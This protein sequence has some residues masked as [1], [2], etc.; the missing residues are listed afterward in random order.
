MRGASLIDER[1]DAFQSLTLGP[2]RLAHSGDVKIYENLNVLPR[3]FIASDVMLSADGA[4]HLK[5]ETL[6][7]SGAQ[8][9]SISVI[10][11]EAER[12][13]IQTTT[14]TPGYLILTDEYYPGWL[15]TVD[16]QPAAITRAYGLFRAVALQ[17]GAHTVEFRFDPP[18]LKLG[19][20][21]SALTLIALIVLFIIHHSTFNIRHS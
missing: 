18:A 19:V 17:P 4:K 12:V 5:A 8:G 2:Y 21:V 15:A 20:M 11:Y 6:R 13:V 1:A 10:K 9:D 3:A 16:G 14:E 7:A